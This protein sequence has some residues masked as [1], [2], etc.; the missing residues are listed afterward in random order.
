MLNISFLFNLM[1]SEFTSREA[2]NSVLFAHVCVHAREEVLFLMHAN[3]LTS[4]AP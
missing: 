3:N 4:S 1:H 2:L